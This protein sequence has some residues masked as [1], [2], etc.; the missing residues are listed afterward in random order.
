LPEADPPLHP[1]EKFFST[2]G[3]CTEVAEGSL[4]SEALVA[5]GLASSKGD[6]KRAFKACTVRMNSYRSPA[7]P[8][9]RLGT[10]AFFLLSGKDVRIV[11]VSHDEHYM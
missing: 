9:R 1:I 2:F 5:C 4:L 10:G 11:R 8:D 6:A 3:G 7:L